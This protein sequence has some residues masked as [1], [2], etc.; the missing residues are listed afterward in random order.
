MNYKG[1]GI[2]LVGDFT[3]KYVSDAQMSS[4]VYL[5]NLLRKYYKIPLNH[6]LGHGQVKGAHT[7]CPGKS[8][9]WERFFSQLKA[10]AN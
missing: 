2:C 7:E 9:P 8:F 3:G 4:L 10:A 1:I 5:V 6:I